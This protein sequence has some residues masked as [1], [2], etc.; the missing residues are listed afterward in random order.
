MAE[1]AALSPN[2]PVLQANRRCAV[3]IGLFYSG[4]SGALSERSGSIAE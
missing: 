1:P 3:R 2:G 4:T